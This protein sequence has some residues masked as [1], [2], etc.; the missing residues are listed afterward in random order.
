MAKVRAGRSGCSVV[1]CT[2]EHK[3]LF[4]P[5]SSEVLRTQW[6]NFIFDGDVPT[7]VPKVLY[8][9]ANH[10]TSD[11]IIN[12]GQYKTGFAKA[13]RIK[14]ESVPTVRDP[15]TNQEAVSLNILF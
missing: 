10:F 13:L 7:A 14:N 2:N 6:V 5:P 11:C 4:K 12:E 3:S 8:V 15:T 9:C 1:G